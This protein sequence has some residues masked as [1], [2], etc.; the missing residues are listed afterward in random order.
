MGNPLHRAMAIATISRMILL[1]LCV[2]PAHTH[3]V[4]MSDEGPVPEPVAK[5]P[6]TSLHR[7]WG[8]REQLNEAKLA[9]RKEHTK[10]HDLFHE[11]EDHSIL[12]EFHTRRR[13]SVVPFVELTGDNF[14]S[15]IGDGSY[16]FVQ[17]HTGKVEGLVNDYG[18]D[19]SFQKAAE[20]FEGIEDSSVRFAVMDAKTH[21]NY[22]HKYHSK[23]EGKYPIFRIFGPETD[24]DESAKFNTGESAR[25]GKYLCHTQH[26]THV[27]E[28]VDL[29]LNVVRW[30]GCYAPTPPTPPVNDSPAVTGEDF[31]RYGRLNVP[32]WMD[33][34]KRSAQSVGDDLMDVTDEL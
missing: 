30:N 1:L 23:A 20:E 12:K 33:K 27:V 15:S 25:R 28:W 26:H 8:L 11:T 6:Q 31:K 29:A 4:P 2:A 7:F 5:N 18:G 22:N 13:G 17:F 24:T 3:N 19:G 10:V 32:K 16:W 21:S 9:H 14:D 34:I